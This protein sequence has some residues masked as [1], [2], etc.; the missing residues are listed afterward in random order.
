MRT[1][2]SVLTRAPGY[3]AGPLTTL[4]PPWRTLGDAVMTRCS[5][6]PEETG[7]MLDPTTH[8]RQVTAVFGHRLPGPMMP[9]GRSGRPPNGTNPA[10]TRVGQG[11]AYPTALAVAS[12]RAR[13]RDPAGSQ[14]K[15]RIGGRV[16]ASGEGVV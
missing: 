1:E 10:G 2:P 6:S 12:H 16:E 5:L 7:A 15:R 13:R 9:R 4:A 3:Y 8:P 11:T 14:R